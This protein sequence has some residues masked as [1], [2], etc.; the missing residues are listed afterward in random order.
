MTQ[1]NDSS[2]LSSIDSTGFSPADLGHLLRLVARHLERLNAPPPDDRTLT[3]KEAAQ[4]LNVSVSY[5]YRHDFPFKFRIGHHVRFSTNGLRA[6]L[7]ARR[8]RE[9]H[10]AE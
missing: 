7:D 10:T 5:L 9:S 8:E 3:A 1:P 2:A 6:W 4:F